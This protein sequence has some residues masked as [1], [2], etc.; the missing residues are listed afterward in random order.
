MPHKCNNHVGWSPLSLGDQSL[1]NLDPSPLFSCWK[2]DYCPI[3]PTNL[4]GLYWKAHLH[5]SYHLSYFLLY[6][7]L[8]MQLRPFTSFHKNLL[9]P[10]TSSVLKEFIQDTWFWV[11]LHHSLLPSSPTSTLLFPTPGAYAVPQPSPFKFLQA[12]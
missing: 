2:S 4:Q 9:I 12:E 7:P 1:L 6:I 11:G 3:I 10:N 8:G 5:H